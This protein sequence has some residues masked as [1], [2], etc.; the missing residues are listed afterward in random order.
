MAAKEME[1]KRLICLPCI[2]EH[3][4]RSNE[5]LSSDVNSDLAESNR[6]TQQSAEPA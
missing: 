5:Q 6:T 3:R 4:I 1:K 2:Q